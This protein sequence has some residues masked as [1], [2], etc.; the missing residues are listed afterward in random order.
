MPI[1]Q[2]GSQPAAVSRLFLL[3]LLLFSAA[4]V[5]GSDSGAVVRY[6]VVLANPDQ[7][8]L[9]IKMDL[10]PG[11]AE[12][13][14][15]L[16]VWNALYQVRDFSQHI[17]WVRANGAKG[18]RLAI[19]PVNKSRWRIEGAGRGAE[20]EYEIA[21]DDPGPYGAQFNAQHAFFNLAEILMYGVDWRSCRIELRFTGVPAGWKAAAALPTASGGEFLAESYDQLVDAPLELGKFKEADFE[22]GGA[23]YRVVVD[24]D[25]AD[26]SLEKIVP[27]VRRI[28]S[29]ATNWMNDRPFESYLF[30]YHFPREGGGGGMEHANSTAIDVNSRVLADAPLSLADVTTHEF[31]HLWNVKRIRPQFH[32]RKL[33]HC[34]V[35]LRRGDGYRPELHRAARRPA[36]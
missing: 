15:Q 32:Q 6:E 36:G 24:A 33:H 20:V 31:F 18:E 23:H 19:R 17:N 13:D 30:L 34:A 11:P 29:A 4:S 1:G 22:E 26:F 7:H 28:V 3:A 14:L 25:P 2:P 27:M 10:G 35:V 8:L 21:A 16:P 5:L 9:D 12:Q